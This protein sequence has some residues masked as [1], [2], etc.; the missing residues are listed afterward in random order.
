MI[1]MGITLR[2]FQIHKDWLSLIYNG[3]GLGLAISGISY[4]RAY[5]RLS[6]KNE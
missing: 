3:V 5:Y 4:F 6:V 2:H 1:A